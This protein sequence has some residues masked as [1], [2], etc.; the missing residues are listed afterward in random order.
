MFINCIKTIFNLFQIILI[1]LSHKIMKIKIN[2][3]V[4]YDESIYTVVAIIYATIYLR[5]S[6]DSDS[7]D[8]DI[9]E[10][11]KDYKDVEFL[12]T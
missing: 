10:V 8:Y 7:Y 4:L 12:Y 3:K 2:D 1:K 11:Y 5:I 9:S 6:Y